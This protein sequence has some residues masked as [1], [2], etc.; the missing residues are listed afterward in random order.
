[1]FADSS[2][3]VTSDANTDATLRQ[4]SAANATSMPETEVV[5]SDETVIVTETEETDKTLAKPRR[6]H[7]LPKLWH[8]I[9]FGVLIVLLLLGAVGGV[10]AYYTYQVGMELRVQAQE[11][12]VHARGAYE[13]FK[14][15]NLPGAQAELEQVAGKLVQLRETYGKL[16]F[17][18]SIPVASTYYGDGIHGLNAADAGVRAGTKSLEAIVPYADVLGFTG[19]GTFTGG[20]AEDRLKLVLE[21]LEKV[22]PQIDEITQEMETVQAELDAINPNR[23][24]EEFQGQPIRSLLEQAQTVADGAVTALTEY[25]PI[26]EQLPA[27][28]GGGGERKKYLILFQNDNE[29]RPTGGFLTAYATIF[30]EDG[31]VIPE[32]SD[33]IYELDKKYPNKPPIPEALGRYLTTESRW[34]LRDMNI[35]PDFKQSMDQFYSQYQTIRSEPQDI[36][37]IIAI[38]THVL[39]ELMRILG[40]VEVPGYGTFS[41]ENDARCDCPQIIYELSNIITRPTPYIREDRKGILGPLMRAILT[42]AYT[43][44]RQNLPE[45]FEAGFKA[46]EGR[47]A[48]MYFF[49]ETFQAA[50]DTINATGRLKAGDPGADFLAIINANLGGAKSNLFI[51]YDVKQTVSAPANGAIT[52]TVE[53]TYKNSRRGDN[54]NLEAGL[55]CLNSTLR[56]WTRLYLPEGAQLVE[57]QGFTQ[58]PKEYEEDG[59]SVIDGFFILEPNSQARLRITYTVPYTDSNTYKLKMWK[60]GGINPVEVVMDVEG[61]EDTFTLDKD[62]VFEAPF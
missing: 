13:S 32:K 37:G 22:T 34:N 62:Y 39:V 60:Q 20:T 27:M 49:D 53:I 51:D 5:N 50:A 12:E 59:F 15:Q 55:L 44:P 58:E 43:A 10:L 40:P 61:G 26:I 11:T 36:D 1:M 25:R 33:D 38:D 56:D 57:A 2:A 18:Q 30:V 3:P 19:E 48:Q 9:A 7:F 54:C 28:A 35:S 47:H 46:L 6:R 17:Y 16:S 21:T 42:K 41:V 8:K 45:L 14:T 29:L 52:K 4:F 23:Y 24:P 31:K